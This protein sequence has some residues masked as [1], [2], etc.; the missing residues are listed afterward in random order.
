[1]N[2]GLG[3]FGTADPALLSNFRLDKYDVTVGRF[4][5]FVTAWKAGWLPPAGSGKHTALNGGQG[6][7]QVATPGTFPDMEYETG[8]D[9]SYDTNIAPMDSNLVCGSLI[10]ATPMIREEEFLGTWTPAAGGQESLPIN[11]V[12]WYE[13]YAFC[14]WDGGFLPSE[15]EWRYAAAGGPQQLQ[16]PWGTTDPGLASQYAIY[17]CYYPSVTY[18]C[19]K[20]TIAPVGTAPSGAGVWGQLDM[21]GELSQWTLDY[22]APSFVDPCTDCVL[23]TPAVGEV[24]GANVH[25][26]FGFL[27]LASTLQTA[28]S[29]DQATTRSFDVGF[30]C[31]RSAL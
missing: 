7:V 31:A 30:R 20:A 15:T 29:H 18:D 17:G 16:Y 23:T 19:T 2:V 11:C 26:G 27:D 5:Q 28:R 22:Y 12:N 24:I 14:I 1:M 10:N 25:P 3:P 21:L 9:P 13:A 6:L 4:R 8:W